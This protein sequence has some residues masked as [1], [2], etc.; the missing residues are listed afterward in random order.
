MQV[1][2]LKDVEGLGR[3][4][5]VKNVTGGYGQ[6]YL[7]PRQLAVPANEGALKQA[8]QVQESAARRHERQV[9]T[10][11]DLAARLDGQNVVFRARAGEGD[12]LYGSI[13]A[14]DIADALQKATGLKVDRRFLEIEHPVKSLGDHRVTVRT[15]AGALATVFVRVERSV[16]ED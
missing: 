7:I 2:L 14:Q 12:R 4:G 6:N 10:A 9:N 1:M 13:T 11:K 5:D 3:A 8:R 16:G 15:G